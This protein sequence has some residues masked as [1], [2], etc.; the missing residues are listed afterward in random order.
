MPN[1]KENK[2]QIRILKKFLG[3]LTPPAIGIVYVLAALELGAQFSNPLHS[4]AVVGLMVIVPM[5]A[6]ILYETWQMAKREVEDE[7]RE[8]MRS[9]ED[10]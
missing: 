10:A 2:M 7:N 8:L 5:V 3:K 1:T 4:I 9:I 6:Y